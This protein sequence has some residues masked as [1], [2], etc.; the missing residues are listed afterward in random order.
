MKSPIITVALCALVG[1][2]SYYLGAK[3]IHDEQVAAAEKARF[4]NDFQRISTYYSALQNIDSGKYDEG[5]KQLDSW[6]AADMEQISTYMNQLPET[7][8]ARINAIR[9]EIS[10][11]REQ[12]PKAYY[13]ESAGSTGE[14]Q[15]LSMLT[16]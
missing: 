10:Q 14:N 16:H 4:T 5:A 6:L 9:V 15:V 1:V 8:R 7:D 12:N 3:T 13:S 2:F 11:Y